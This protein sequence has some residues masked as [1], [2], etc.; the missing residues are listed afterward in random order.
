MARKDDFR[1]TVIHCCMCGEPIGHDRPKMALTCSDACRDARKNY[2]RSRQDQRACRYCLQP[3]TP[4]ERKQFQAWRRWM[5]KNPPAEPQPETP[6]EEPDVSS[7][8]D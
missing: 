5:K 2:R 3:S 1:N 8:V 4:E 7:H 6:Q